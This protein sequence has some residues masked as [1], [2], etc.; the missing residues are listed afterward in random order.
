MSFQSYK[1]GKLAPRHDV[2]TLQFSSYVDAAKLP[3]LP[4]WVRW[5]QYC[6]AFGTMLNDRIGDCAIAAPGHAI[7]VWTA[8]HGSQVTLPDSS[9]LAAYSAVSGYDPRTGSNDNGCVMLDVLNYWRGKGIGGRKIGAFVSLN[10][11]DKTEIKEGIYLFGGVYVGVALPKAW[12]S[13]KVWTAPPQFRNRINMRP[14]QP[15]S[16]GGHAVWAVD[17]DAQYVTVI[18]WGQLVKMEWAAFTTYVDESYACV[19]SEWTTNTTKA[20]NGFAI[21]ALMADLQTLGAN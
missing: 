3:P 18:T 21:D 1:L 9:I 2:R 4:Q 14:W 10:S 20:P 6:K 12:Q 11:R 5:S 19:S 8:N 15:G 7:Q 17:F 16:W 13:Q